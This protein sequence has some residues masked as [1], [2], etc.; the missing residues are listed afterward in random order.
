MANLRWSNIGKDLDDKP[1][2]TYIRQK[3]GGRFSIRLMPQTL[4]ILERYRPGEIRLSGYIFPILN[5]ALHTTATQR[6]NR[7]GK[8]MGQ[9]N[10]DLKTVGAS[11]GIETPLTTYVARH[12]FATAL[13]R[14]GVAT[15]IIS[16]AMGH[17]D[18]R[19]T[20]IYLSEFETDLVDAAFENL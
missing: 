3:T 15:G 4:A 9:V 7:C 13:K 11:V 6:Q 5:T 14:S 2:L 17:S 16:E 12:S 8:V 1:R 18:E 20:Q 10:V 19:T